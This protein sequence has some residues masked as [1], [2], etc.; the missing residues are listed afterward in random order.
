M[1]HFSFEMKAL[2]EALTSKLEVFRSWSCSCLS[3]EGGTWLFHLLSIKAGSCL[4]LV[5]RTPEYSLVFF[6]SFTIQRVA[7]DKAG[8]VFCYVHSYEG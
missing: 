5:T 6:A 8:Y 1:V 4:L 3:E 2:G 7:C